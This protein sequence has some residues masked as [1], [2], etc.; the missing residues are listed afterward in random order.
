MD[1]SVEVVKL[2]TQGL[3]SAA[4]QLRELANATDRLAD[5]D[6]SAFTAQHAL[7]A[8][9]LLASVVGMAGTM[10]TIN[11]LDTPTGTVVPLGRP[12]P[13]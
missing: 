2:T 5:G 3:H 10:R 7:A 11:R 13:T 1:R 9:Q 8:F 12:H 4:A 6:T